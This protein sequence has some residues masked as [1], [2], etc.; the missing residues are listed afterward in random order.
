M[1]K[2]K[3]TSVISVFFSGSGRAR[4]SVF[5]LKSCFFFLKSR[6]AAPQAAGLEEEPRRAR[7]NGEEGPAGPENMKKCPA[8]P[9]KLAE[10]PRRAR[11]CEKRPR[12]ARKNEKRPRRARKNEE[13]GP[14]GPQKSGNG[15]FLGWFSYRKPCSNVY[16]LGPGASRKVFFFSGPKVFFFL[17]LAG[18]VFFLVVFCF[19]GLKKRFVF[20]SL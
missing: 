11:K 12:R 7:K 3:K 15:V 19:I 10:R 17:D 13:K 16:F 8:G 20:T 14:K 2:K 4:E 18:R 6:L 5:F 1:K 9:E